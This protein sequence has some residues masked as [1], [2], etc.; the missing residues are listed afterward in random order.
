MKALV[1]G[2]AGWIGGKLVEALRKRS[3]ETLIFDRHA[4]RDGWHGDVASA[5]DVFSAVHAFAPDVIFHLAGVLGTS[6]LVDQASD[7]IA[8][9]TIGTVNVL[10]AAKSAWDA[11]RTGPRVKPRVF[12]PTKPNCWLNTYSITKEA[13]EKF[14]LMYEAQFGLDVRVMRWLNAYGPGQKL[15]PVRKAVPHMIM[16]ALE[17]RPVE[18]YGDGEQFAHLIHVDDLVK[19]TIDYTLKDKCACGVV[20]PGATHVSTVRRMAELITNLV[21]LGRDRPAPI[22]NLPMR[23]GEDGT[24]ISMLPTCRCMA[25]LTP[26]GLVQGLT[27]TIAWYRERGVERAAAMNFYAK[28]AK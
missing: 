9:N 26:V 3:I 21:S 14:S 28:N 15:H 11:N 19:A 4:T 2:G 12:Y 18:V 24:L 5:T 22:V 6:E 27:D 23:R 13:G 16:M 25:P 8:A 1:T 20:D 10:N 17:G 7:A